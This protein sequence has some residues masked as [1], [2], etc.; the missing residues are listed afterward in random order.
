[1]KFLCH[2]ATDW[3]SDFSMEPAVSISRAEVSSGRTFLDCIYIG[4]VTRGGKEPVP[5]PGQ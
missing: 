1:M 2:V 4:L 3:V 5:S